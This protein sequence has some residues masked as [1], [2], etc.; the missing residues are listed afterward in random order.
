MRI[1]DWIID[2]ERDRISRDG[3]SIKLERRATAVLM[4]FANNPR[5]VVSKDELIEHVWNGMAVSDHSV[6]IVISDLRKALGDDR[7]SPSYIETIP[8]RG[9][10]LVATI[11]ERAVADE[12]ARPKRKIA[13]AGAA[14]AAIAL[15]AFA[16]ATAQSDSRSGPPTLLV[17]DIANDS[18]SSNGD[19][20]AFA[21]PELLVT[22]L[23]EYPRGA[24][25]RVRDSQVTAKAK[26]SAIL[27][28]RITREGDQLSAYFNLRRG[29]DGKI[30]WA[31]HYPIRDQNLTSVARA[32]A[33]S[34]STV[35]GADIS[36][37][38]HALVYSPASQALYWEAKKLASTRD[39]E[40]LRAARQKLVE[41]LRI[42][43]GFAAA[44]AALANIYAHKS[45]E[46]LGIPRLDTFAEAENHLKIAEQLA[47]PSSETAIT[48]AL[49]SVFRDHDLKAARAYSERAVKLGPLDP[50]AWQSLAMTASIQG[51][52]TIAIRSIDRANAL[53]PRR[54][55]L[56]TDRVWMLYAAGQTTAARE[57]ASQIRTGGSL[58]AMYRALIET[59]R[60][61]DRAAF[62]YWIERA[63]ARGLDEASLKS[64]QE[65]ST[66][67]PAGAYRR[68]ADSVA[69]TEAYDENEVALAAMYRAAGDEGRAAR[70]LASVRRT[71][72][73][74][75]WLWLDRVPELSGA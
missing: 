9:Y 44:H 29:D 37:P 21:L 10:R 57:A 26:Q 32:V 41:A 36:L 15:G 55:D 24:L 74:W 4:H 8:K 50:D 12:P 66:K 64:A 27:A 61:D 46:H 51:D 39:E 22:N 75:L 45:G 2:P 59:R 72:D 47:S 63:R 25:V 54:I 14:A 30:L 1:G 17:A 58:L 56:R 28:G 18:G 70:T 23:S 13:I 67:D 5:R 31:D 71:R 3:E 49:I 53:D 73:S 40:G 65:Q 7:A 16:V 35:L 62:R 43:P 48:R 6:A 38:P 20:L 60:G 52:H 11:C 34:A 68:L 33:G 69:R 42:A 19:R